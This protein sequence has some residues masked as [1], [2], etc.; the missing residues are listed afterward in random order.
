MTKT[1]SNIG[2]RHD[3]RKTK[4]KSFGNCRTDFRKENAGQN[5][6]GRRKHVLPTLFLTIDEDIVEVSVAFHAAVNKTSHVTRR[7]CQILK[8]GINK[9]SVWVKNVPVVTMPDQRWQ[10]SA[11]EA[12][13][14]EPIIRALL[15]TNSCEQRNCNVF[16]V[17][18]WRLFI[19]M[20]TD[21]QVSEVGDTCRPAAE[22]GRG[23]SV[24]MEWISAGTAHLGF[25]ALLSVP[26]LLSCKIMMII[27]DPDLECRLFTFNRL[28]VVFCHISSTTGE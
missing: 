9:V 20:V 13:T 23:R 26:H 18:Q 8:L 15:Q 14:R 28:L 16:I 12:S 17:C 19:K 24:Q 3:Q 10:S 7:S 25:P 4:Y 27:L 22:P 21:W 6:T 2:T 5:C 11:K 1:V